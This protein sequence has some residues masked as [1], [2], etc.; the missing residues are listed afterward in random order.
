[1]SGA[2]M[3]PSLDKKTEIAYYDPFDVLSEIRDTFVS[4][5]PLTKLHW[6]HPLRPLRTIE[7]LDVDLVEETANSLATPKH[8]MLGLSPEP[9]L[10]IAFVKCEDNDTY[11]GTIRKIIREWFEKNVTGVRDPTEWLIVHYVP[12]GGKTSSSTRFKYGVFDKIKID[13][14]TDS[15]QDRVLQIRKDYSTDQARTEAWKELMTKIKE[16]LLSSFSKRVD[17]YQNEVNKLE[18]EKHVLGW[19]FGKFFIMKEGLAL[20]FE[21]MNLFEDALLLY[22]ELEEAFTQIQQS[23][24]ITFF[25]D[26]GFEKLPEPLLSLQNNTTMRHS[27]L[28]NTVSLFDFQSYLF[29]RQAY[30]L[31][32]IAKSAPSPSIG[33]MKIGELFLRLR[34]FLGEMT[35]LLLSNKKNQYLVAEWIYNVAQEFLASTSWVES[36][37]VREVAEGR[38][39]LIVILRTS[40]ETI[41]ASEGWVI[42][43]VLSDISLEDNFVK[44][45]NYKITNEIMKSNLTSSSIFFEEYRSLTLQALAE[46]KMTDKGRIQ[47]RLTAQLALLEYQLG[48]YESTAKLLRTIPD[49]F[50]SEGWDLVS[51]SLL[52][53]Y[54][55]C[56]KHFDQKED[57]LI[58]SLELLSCH[59]YL[60]PEDVKERIDV[61]QSLADLV[62]CSTSLDNFFTTTIDTNVTS[63][64]DS[65]TYILRVTF[66][67]PLKFPFPINSATIT[68]RNV[69]DSSD[70]L[71]FEV[72]GANPIILQPGN[73]T[74]KF[75]NR[76]FEQVKFK[77]TALFMIRGK[78]SFT[79]NYSDQAPILLQ[80]YT[81]KNNFH[82]RYQVPETSMLTERR[83]GILLEPGINDV[84]GGTVAFKSITPGLKLIPQKARNETYISNLTTVNVSDNRSSVISFTN[85]GSDQKAMISVPYAIDFDVMSVKIRA[86]I[87]YKTEKGEF[88]HILE[89]VLDISL[90]LSVNVQDFYKGDKLFSKFLISCNHMEK[91]VRILETNLKS[92]K[93]FTTSTPSG[94]NKPCVS[95][96]LTEFI[97]IY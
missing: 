50:R 13:F 45:K 17:L 52:M 76:R 74:L 80:L 77:I 95:I 59:P 18:T 32:C 34:S 65:D 84:I 71:S 38:G 79:K 1:M 89:D 33:F 43:G 10:K 72:K 53:I 88:Q 16:G 70:V 64:S 29:S 47:T 40:L 7:K 15:K 54:V 48:N 25:S 46:F 94:T 81:S 58:H 44:D 36:S 55:N 83:I 67:N 57:M 3:V 31:L 56:L 22:D 5:F 6:N 63:V 87:N 20:A 68:M 66:L 35:G 73:T 42:E 60:A 86:I 96:F 21:R 90:A 23:K 61:V 41:A 92:T 69:N 30:L 78:L 14:N 24:A 12:S 11:R 82:A 26:I 49:I 8:Q 62:S 2:N 85:I 28:S 27:I 93:N 19:N 37:V 51:T 4:Q 97:K 75:E 9:Y 91:P 39:E